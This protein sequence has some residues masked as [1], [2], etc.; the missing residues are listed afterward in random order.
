M[1][2]SG[3]G[4]ASSVSETSQ[5]DEPY[6]VRTGSS[7]VSIAEWFES[8]CMSARSLEAYAPNAPF[9]LVWTLPLRI[10]T[11]LVPL[12]FSDAVQ[13]SSLSLSSSSSIG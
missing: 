6:L 5:P 9:V 7:E 2:C 11:Q 4:D 13:P 1:A 3:L 10:G 12:E 8:N